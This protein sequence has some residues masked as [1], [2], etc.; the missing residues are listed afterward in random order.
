MINQQ[1]FQQ[2]VDLHTAGNL[3]AAWDMYQDLDKENSDDPGLIHLMGVLAG[4]VGNLQESVRL[5]ERAITLKPGAAD[6]YR[7]LAIT[8]HRL[9]NVPMAANTFSRLGGMLTENEH[10]DR[11]IDAFAEAFK[12]EPANEMNAN[13]LGAALNRVGRYAEAKLVLEQALAP[14]P[15][16]PADLR[17]WTPD[18]PGNRGDKYTKQLPALHLNL[19]NTLHGLGDIEGA[20]E[21]FRR[22]LTLKPDS[23]L[24][25][26][27]L[28]LA[29]LLNGELE[30]GWREYE[31]RWRQENYQPHRWFTQPVWR[32]ESPDAIGGRLLISTEQGYG[33]IIQFARFVPQL[34]DRGYDV[35]FEVKPELYKLMAA[36]IVHPGV[37]VIP[38]MEDPTKVYQDLPF[39]MHC[40]ILSLGLHMGVT[41]DNIPAATPY[42]DIDQ[43]RRTLWATRFE[44]DPNRRKIGI[45]W[46]GNPAHPRNF[47][48]SMPP[49][50]WAPLLDLP[51]TTFYSLQKGPAAEYQFPEATAKVI[52][53]DPELADF[54]DTAAA[55]ANLDLVIGVDTSVMHLAGA[56]GVPA[57]IM[58]T[59]IADWRWGMRGETTPWYPSVC[60]FRQ[61]ENHD[62]AGVMA[63]VR[64][65]LET[66]WEN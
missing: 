46:G 28:S 37:Q 42:L 2:A 47:L 54:T 7:N 23:V 18:D 61:Q 58:V 34:A 17:Y 40:G 48:R 16:M 6:F 44:R 29:L 19:G 51:D 66:F 25:H 55:I 11:A 60:L 9:E 53:L 62:W 8:Y 30:E 39:A 20:I 35:L 38:R 33:D 22:V 10:F 4:Q 15:K 5:I 26:Y 57:W 50:F 49:E 43:E 64:A 65:A 24:G 52:T 63:E 13:N 32:G 31:W 41:L 14:D 12:M 3:A 45:V 36:G 21:S 1:R 56:L 59:K 27:D